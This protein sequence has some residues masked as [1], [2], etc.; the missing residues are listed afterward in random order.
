MAN[1]PLPSFAPTGAGLPSASPSPGFT[2]LWKTFMNARLLMA[3]ALLVLDWALTVWSK[4]LSALALALCIAYLPCAAAVRLLAR[5]RGT[6]QIFDL[7]WLYTVGVDLACFMALDALTVGSINFTPLLVLPVLEAAVL[8]TR[9]LALGTAALAGILLLSDV[10]LGA[11]LHQ[12][13]FSAVDLAQAALTSAAIMALGWLINQQ[14]ARLAREEARASRNWDEAR[15]LTR[16]NSMVI[17][18][19]SDGVLV[20]DQQRTVRMANPAVCRMIGAPQSIASQTFDLNDE[21][22]WQALARLADLTFTNGPQGPTEITL[23][24]P[25]GRRSHLRVR[26]ER[27]AIQSLA[28]AGLCVMFLQ[29]L[30]EIEAQVRT[31]K[32]AAM[33][34]MSAAVAHEIRNPLAAIAQ[35][36]AL[37][38]EDLPNS[39]A[40]RLTTIVR[41]NADRLGRIVDDILGIAR[42]HGQNNTD[43]TQAVPLDDLVAETCNDWSRQHATGPRLTVTQRVPG[44]QVQ[45]SSE[46]LRRILINLLD[47]AARYASP[48]NGAIQIETQVEGNVPRLCVWSDGAPLEPSVRRHLFEP[49]F[50]SESRSSGLGLYICRE[51]CERHD[52]TI[53]Y[54]R[55]V[56]PLEGEAREGNAFHITFRRAPANMHAQTQPRLFGSPADAQNTGP[57]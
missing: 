41:Q 53:I 56:Q 5:P 24:L 46:H 44:I 20:V 51:L 14:T 30:R 2:R 39:A 57:T 4:P 33:G 11:F 26:T 17:E 7:Q 52:A 8:G 38:A 13:G 10:L 40:Q 35:A 45:F 54:E 31:E 21:P 1:T 42:A 19:L 28:G 9:A 34:R 15:T 12:V 43:E 37:L 29:D 48:R 22:A 6:W 55:T 3:L 25:D 47:N 23:P 50:S 27:T 36:N 16:V 49:F 32:L 18:S